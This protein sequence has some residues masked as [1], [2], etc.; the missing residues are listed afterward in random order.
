[1]SLESQSKP[2]LKAPLNAKIAQ[3]ILNICFW[4]DRA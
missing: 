3:G 2:R 1:M 4:S